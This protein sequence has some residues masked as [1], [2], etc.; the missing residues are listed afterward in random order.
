[1]DGHGRSF[2]G[3]DELANGA[4]EQIGLASFTVS[5]R[6]MKESVRNPPFSVIA[7]EAQVG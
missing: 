2:S 1:M 4:H 6:G 3:G 5:L 7:P